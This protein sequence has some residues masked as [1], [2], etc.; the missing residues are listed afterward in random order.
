MGGNCDAAIVLIDVGLPISVYLTGG[1]TNWVGCHL[2]TAVC[3]VDGGVV[4]T[5]DVLFGSVLCACLLS[6][7]FCGTVESEGVSW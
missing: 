1:Y 2:S 4:G 7:P 6:A 3:S 5:I